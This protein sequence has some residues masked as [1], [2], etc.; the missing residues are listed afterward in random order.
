MNMPTIEHDATQARKILANLGW[1][2]E[3][4]LLKKGQ[5]PWVTTIPTT[6][7]EFEVTQPM[8]ADWGKYTHPL[9][10]ALRQYDQMGEG[11]DIIHEGELPDMPEAELLTRIMRLTER[12]DALKAQ[13][14]LLA[15]AARTEGHTG[16]EIATALGVTEAATYRIYRQHADGNAW[17]HDD[18]LKALTAASGELRKVEQEREQAI[19]QAHESGLTHRTIAPFANVKHQTLSGIIARQKWV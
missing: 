15:R 12:R 6:E 1:T 14:I 17:E 16:R 18:V 13:R 5:T 2:Y 7:G 19:V 4:P 9:Y 11:R 8:L 10:W 3:L